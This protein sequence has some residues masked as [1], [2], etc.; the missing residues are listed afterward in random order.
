MARTMALVLEYEGTAYRGFQ[1]QPNGPTVQGRLNEALAALTGGP[2][3]T[4][5]AG[6][7][8][9]GAHARGQVVSF[10]SDSMLPTAVFVSGLNAHLPE[11]IAVQS[12]REVASDFDARRSAVSRWYRYTILRRPVRSAMERSWTNRIRAVLDVPAMAAAAA[13]L[14]GEHDF[15]SFT[16]PEFGSADA[17]RTMFRAAITPYGDYLLVDMEAT[18]FLPQQVRRTVG[19]LLQVGVRRA[20]V[21]RI[22]CLLR[23]PRLGAAGAGVTAQGL[24]LMAVRYSRPHDDLAPV[25]THYFGMPLEITPC[26]P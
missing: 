2:V 19:A 8:D 24:C 3:R 13:A 20:P 11:D 16:T 21:D 1:I 6:R 18:A 17:V 14:L 23:A 10:T 5:G 15:A 7:T 4:I 12:C 26:I 9:A 22:A 25:G